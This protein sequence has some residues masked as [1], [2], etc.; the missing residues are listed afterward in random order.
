MSRIVGVG[1]AVAI[2]I[3]AQVGRSAQVAHV[4]EKQEITLKAQNSY[5]SPYL[6]VDVWVDLSGPGFNK[7]VYGFWDGDNTFRVR[8]LATVPGDWSWKSGSNQADPGLNGKSDTF[9]AVAWSEAEK[10]KNPNRRGFIRATPNG[11]ALEY[12]DGTPYLILGDTL[13]SIGTWRYPW[14]YD[15]TPRPIGPKA[16]FKD[17][18]RLRESQGY[19][20][21]TVMAAFP[22]WGQ[23][24]YPFGVK[25]KEGD[26]AIQIRG[27]W[28]AP[29]TDCC[30]DP[31]HR[32][33]QTQRGWIAVP[34]SG[35]GAR[36]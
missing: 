7:R 26:R 36:L 29:G 17:Y 30:G 14:F 8:I 19:N 27:A 15:E 34:L 11:H 12:A 18:V 24:R 25:I 31:A 33:K 16:G 6:S 3:L 32:Q 35:Q 10:E 23:D 1:L 4:W 2:A 20:L 13:W 21:V 28:P 5:P 9:R 22:G